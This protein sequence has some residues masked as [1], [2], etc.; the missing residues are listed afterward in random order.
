MGNLELED[1]LSMKEKYYNNYYIYLS[2]LYIRIY[3]IYV[4]VVYNKYKTY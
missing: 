2:I 4:Y 1:F 3:N